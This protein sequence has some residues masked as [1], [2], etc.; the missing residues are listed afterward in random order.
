M[1]T[2]HEQGH[3]AAVQ[4]GAHGAH[5]HAQHGHAHH[6][7][8]EDRVPAFIGLIAGAA[9]IGAVLFGVVKWTNAQFAGHAEGAKAEATK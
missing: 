7:V 5:G 3:G 4:H 1:A 2:H 6:S 9:F 8:S